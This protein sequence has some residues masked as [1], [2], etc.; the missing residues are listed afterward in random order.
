MI[1]LLP[2]ESSHLGVVITSSFVMI[3]F[4]IWAIPLLWH[5]IKTR[6]QAPETSYM[7]LVLISLILVAIALFFIFTYFLGIDL[8]RGARYN[9]VYFPAV[10]TL[11][12]ASL[13]VCRQ[14]S[15]GNMQRWG[16]GGKQAVLLIWL[17]GFFSFITV[18][19]NLAYQKYYRPELFVDLIQNTSNQPVI[20]ATTH[21]THVQIG[22]MMG[23]G[24]E[25]KLTNSRLNPLFVLAHQGHNPQT[26]TNS[27]GC[28]SFSKTGSGT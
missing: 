9:F 25:L 11:L 3:V 28:D 22:E 6:L 2:V 7:T 26:S 24:R 4:F 13:G 14:N 1:S 19:S 17:M 10:I 23:I 16:I 20:I 21:K 27:L 18:V 8:T 12:A 15:Q 5:G